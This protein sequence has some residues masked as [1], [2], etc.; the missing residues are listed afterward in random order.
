MSVVTLWPHLER[1]SKSRGEDE[2][3]DEVDDEVDALK[4]IKSRMYENQLIPDD[5]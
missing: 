4:L 1:G 5:N 3:D 2:A